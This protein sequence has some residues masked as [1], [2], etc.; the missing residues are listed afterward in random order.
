[1]PLTGRE[2][3]HLQEGTNVLLTQLKRLG[4]LTV[5][6]LAVATAALMSPASAQEGEG[7]DGASA[8]VAE[9]DVQPLTLAPPCAEV[10]LRSSFLTE[11]EDVTNLCGRVLRLKVIVAF[12]PDSACHT[13]DDGHSLTHTHGIAG[14]FDR[15]ELC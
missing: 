13:V 6:T 7:G 12:G 1:V 8:T 5:A 11:Y 14:R 3:C 15:L 9:E 10:R 4:A 2:T